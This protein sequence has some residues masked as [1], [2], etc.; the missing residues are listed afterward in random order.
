MRQWVAMAEQAVAALQVQFQTAMG[1]L[2][3]QNIELQTQLT[4]SQQQSANEVETLRQEVAAA[5]LGPSGPPRQQYA[6]GVDTRLLGKPSDF[7]GT[8]EA[9]R[10]WSAV[11]KGYVG[12]VLPRLQ[13]LMPDAQSS[14]TAIV[15]ATIL[16][17]VDRAASAQLYWML[18]MI[19][20]G[21]ALNIVLLAGD[22]EGLEAWRQLCEMYEPKMR[23]LFAGQLMSILS[24]SLQGDVGERLVAWEREI[25]VYERGS[26]KALDD[27]VKIGTFLLRL[28]ESSLKTHLLMRVDT[29]T[30]WTDFRSE[31]VAISRAITAAQAQPA[32]MDVSAVGKGKKGKGNQGGGRGGYQQ[33]AVC[34]RCGAANHQRANC[35]HADKTCHKCG[36][37]GHLGAVCRSAATTGGG[38]GKGSQK[39]PK[40]KGKGS[41]KTCW[42]CNETGHVSAQCPKKKKVNA[43]DDTGAEPENQLALYDANNCAIS[44]YF[45]LGMV[46]AA[47]EICA[48]GGAMVETGGTFD[49]EI[50][51]GAEVSCLPACIGADT[52]PLHETRLSMCHGYHVVA[53]G[54]KL[55]ELGARILGLEAAA[56]GGESVNLLVRFRVMEIGK[57]LLST[58]DLSRC[59]WETV[60]P[61]GGASAY[62][63]RPASGT[64]IDL[65]RKRCAWYLRA[66]L[67]PHSESPLTASEEFMEVLSLGRMMGVRPVQEGG[68]SGSG[69]AQDAEDAECEESEKV[70]KMVKPTAPSAA[71]REEHVSSGHAV[72]RT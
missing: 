72:F 35:P 21:A 3:R 15:N 6:M 60:F 13:R 43:V 67:K 53:G 46:S 28:P 64:R 40:G 20:K 50:D 38:G 63:H 14:A 58:Q 62:L 71:E 17:D 52:Y 34:S 48:V 10:D 45:D 32:P 16:E 30:A 23:T 36:K 66:T 18:L 42:N 26:G 19:C 33:S 49:I 22:S 39:A 69:F 11:F 31:V 4:Y 25:A 24:F 9:W 65:V 47:E 68:A 37:V 61:A 57:A 44:S 8:Q 12:A 70:K 5:T 55:H 1:E 27:E 51:S 54:G 2:Q 29:L 41:G 56:D 7:Q 59:G